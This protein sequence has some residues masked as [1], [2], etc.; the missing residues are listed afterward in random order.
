[1]YRKLDKDGGKM[2]LN[3]LARDKNADSKDVKGDWGGE[4]PRYYASC[5][6]VTREDSGCEDNEMGGTGDR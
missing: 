3:M 2:I 5:Y 1:M 6:E 4:V